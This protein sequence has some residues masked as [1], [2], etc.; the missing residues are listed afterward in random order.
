MSAKPEWTT[1]CPDWEE[2]IVGRRSLIPFDPL[3]P[4]EAEAA[5]AVFKS[6]R[7]VDVPGSPTFG[8]ACDQ[9]VFDFVA[10]IFG[11][12]DAANATRLIREFLL[13]ISKKNAKSTIAAGIMVTALIRNWR[14]SAELLVLAPTIEVANNCFKPASDMVAADPELGDLLHVVEHQR[15]IR[16]RV[17][18]AELKIVAADKETV[19]GKKA[20]FVL[21]EELWLFGK[22]AGADAML[23]EATGGLVARPEGFVIYLSTH[24]DEPPA[25]VF[26]DKLDYFREVRD[27]AVEDPATLPVLYEWPKALLEQQAYLDPKFFYVTN[28]NL[29]RSVSPSWLEDELRKALRG[30]GDGKQVFLA[31]HLNVEIGVRL[32]RD[33]WRGAD[34]WEA[35]G[36]AG[37]LTFEQLLERCEVVVAGVDGGGLDDLFALCVAGRE[38]VTKRWLLWFHAWA[39]RAVLD[40]R[41]EIA[42]AL[43]DFEADGDLTLCEDATQDIVEVVELCGR[44]K[45]SG[46]LPEKG[47]IG[48]DP[49]NIGVLVDGLASIGLDA[50]QVVGVPQGFRLSSAVW[51]MERKLKD[52]MIGHAGSRMMNWCVGNAKAEQRGNAVLI[53]KEAAG[54]AKIDPLVAAFNAVKL[55]E[56]NPEALGGGLDD[57][58]ASLRPAA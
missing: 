26:K 14:L 29:G 21:V 23:R 33:R 49:Q 54:K 19:S 52:R 2:R 1:A 44:V 48:L 16:H 45:A 56:V 47:A 18:R 35:A 5:L 58:L 17:T 40:L 11:A 24:S 12:Y 36:L 22:K 27:G 32:S 8:E 30:E 9:F 37:G 39:Q 3:F 4:D 53:T 13:L 43:L 41:K 51:S 28:P 25:G 15:L 7:M 34:L 38:R 20:A 50:P 10:A 46:L 6:L 57:W 31:K 55:L 42:P